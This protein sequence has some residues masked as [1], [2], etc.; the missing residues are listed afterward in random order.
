MSAVNE[1][2][3]SVEW[4]TAIVVE[5]AAGHFPRRFAGDFRQKYAVPGVYRW[6][7]L[8]IPGEP[9]EPIYIGEAEDIAN[10]VQR[11]LTPPRRTSKN[12]TNARL[13]TIF[14]N[15]VTARR[16][17]ALDIADVEPFEISGIRFGR[18]EM[19]DRFKRRMVENLMLVIAEKSG[20]FELL[21]IVVE[22][23]DK[24]QRFIRTLKPHEK[25]EIM[26]RYGSSKS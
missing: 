15:H 6:R 7:V 25:R 5:P 23:L 8:R 24:I 2:N 22:P 16:T 12:N 20:H 18:D 10:R 4:R 1:F 17:V 13:N 3:I 11:V 19:G 14:T 21:N 26:R 9:R